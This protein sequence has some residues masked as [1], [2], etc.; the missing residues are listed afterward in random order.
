MY[1][2]LHPSPLR[3]SH[4]TFYAMD[5]HAPPTPPMTQEPPDQWVTGQRGRPT[6][7]KD[8][9]CTDGTLKDPVILQ[10]DSPPIVAP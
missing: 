6:R 4:L 8:F 2:I 5:V 1:T 10:V 3:P 7:H 9:Y